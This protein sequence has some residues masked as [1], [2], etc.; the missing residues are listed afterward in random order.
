MRHDY[1]SPDNSLNLTY[2]RD[3]RQV[4]RTF[5]QCSSVRVVP[6]VT[7]TAPTGLTG[8]GGTNLVVLS[9]TAVTNAT[10]Y[11]VQQWDSVSRSWII[12][13]HSEFTVSQ[14][15]RTAVVRGLLADTTYYHQVRAVN[16]QIRSP[17]V[18]GWS[19]TRT[20]P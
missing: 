17:W 15:G 14:T 5:L 1:P 9:W 6:T 18:Q 19:T 8:S 7:L 10:S 11:E 20:R 16:G 3:R 4:L 2:F 12:L 13:P